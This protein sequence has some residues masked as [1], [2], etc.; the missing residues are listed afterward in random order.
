[1]SHFQSCIS[2]DYNVPF[3]IHEKMYTIYA[4]IEQICQRSFL[5]DNYLVPSRGKIQG[6]AD[7]EVLRKFSFSLIS[8][9]CSTRC[10]CF[11]T[12]A[13][14]GNTSSFFCCYMLVAYHFVQFISIA[15]FGC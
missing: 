5:K 14:V 13:S 9:S 7:V 6:S 2:S 11:F 15:N 1:M 4:T 8:T 10:S 12:F 3:L